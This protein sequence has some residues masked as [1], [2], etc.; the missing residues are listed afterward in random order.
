MNIVCTPGHSACITP[1]A[2]RVSQSTLIGRRRP[3]KGV[4]Y[5]QKD[6]VGHSDLRGGATT[7]FALRSLQAI[8]T[9]ER[10]ICYIPRSIWPTAETL[11]MPPSSHAI[12][13]SNG[14]VRTNITTLDVPLSGIAFPAFASV[15]SYSPSR[16]YD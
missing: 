6:H 2:N 15:Q 9:C 14:R 8:E 13:S 1:Q 5:Q 7:P 4:V 3:R 16:L 12:D 10:S 11:P